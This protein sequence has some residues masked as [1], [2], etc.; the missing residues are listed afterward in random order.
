MV[1]LKLQQF[2]YELKKFSLRHL[3]RLVFSMLFGPSDSPP[4]GMGDVYCRHK[5]TL[6]LDAE[7]CKATDQH[8][9]QNTRAHRITAT[10]T[11][12]HTYGPFLQ[13]YKATKHILCWIGTAK[14]MVPKKTQKCGNTGPSCLDK[15]VLGQRGGGY[16]AEDNLAQLV[17]CRPMTTALLSLR[18]MHRH[19]HTTTAYTRRVPA[20]TLPTIPHSLC[21]AALQWLPPSAVAL[22]AL[23]FHHPTASGLCLDCHRPD[24]DCNLSCPDKKAAK[25]STR[26]A[27][28]QTR[29]STKHY[30]AVQKCI[31]CYANWMCFTKQHSALSPN[32]SLQFGQYQNL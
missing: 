12:C 18:H 1:A 25:H 5:P 22:I 6:P 20:Q 10:P 15:H 7:Q 8:T 32:A 4:Q 30:V 19:S 9:P 29:Q 24:L 11:H 26:R 31:L 2:Q 14:T 28:F 17:S 21:P 3:W 27:Q 23:H 16:A 13:L